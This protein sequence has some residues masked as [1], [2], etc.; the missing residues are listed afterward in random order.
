MPLIEDPEVKFLGECSRRLQEEHRKKKKNTWD[1]SPFGWLVA[2]PSSREKGAIG[3]ELVSSYLEYKGFDVSRPPDSEADRIVAGKRVEIKM[4][5][6]WKNGIYKFQ[7][8][9][10][11]NYDFVICLGVSP[12][13][14]HCW[15]IPKQ[16]IIDKWHD[17]E[18]KDIRSQHGGVAATET[19]WLQVRPQSPS[20]WIREWGGSLV[21]GVGKIAEITGQK[22]RGL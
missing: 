22:L 16:I 18:V 13:D 7:Q 2:G 20:E 21:E 3:E 8:L 1:E 4:S 5:T 19:A 6:L 15:V 9:R 10:D 12:F 17:D 14:V 11:Q